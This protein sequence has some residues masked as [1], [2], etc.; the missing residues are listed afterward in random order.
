[1]VFFLTSPAAF[2][3]SIII[4]WFV[5]NKTNRD[6]P[7]KKNTD[8]DVQHP[9]QVIRLRC[10]PAS[11]TTRGLEQRQEEAGGW[12]VSQRVNKRISER[13]GER[14][15]DSVVGWMMVGLAGGCVNA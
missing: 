6:P 8:S 11:R 4:T 14:V 2:H 15:V 1:M 13:V 3:S 7:L 10:R 5:N 9:D 12:S